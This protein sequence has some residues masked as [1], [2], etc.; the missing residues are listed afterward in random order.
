MINHLTPQKAQQLT[1]ERLQ[2][3]LE[4]EIERMVNESPRDLWED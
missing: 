2:K 1:D 4:S 3:Q